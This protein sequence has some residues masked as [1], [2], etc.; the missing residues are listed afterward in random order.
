MKIENLKIEQVVKNYKEL[1]E[2][3]NV[4]AKAG[5]KSKQLQHKEFNQGT[6]TYINI[7]N[8]GCNLRIE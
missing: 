5:G 3:L 7:S 2:L 4:E 6:N 8:D 1:C